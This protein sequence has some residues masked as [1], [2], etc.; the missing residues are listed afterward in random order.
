MEGPQSPTRVPV[1]TMACAR[2]LERNR[3]SIP[4]GQF[5]LVRAANSHSGAAVPHRPHPARLL[6]LVFS[7]AGWHDRGSMVAMW[8]PA[9]TLS[10]RLGTGAVLAVFVLLVHSAHAHVSGTLH[11]PRLTMPSPPP[12][13]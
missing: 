7:G 12:C 11:T 4:K 10:G 2:P 9:A 6:L 13:R 8:V 1:L 5:K 3:A